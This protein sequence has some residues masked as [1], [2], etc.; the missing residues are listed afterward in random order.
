MEGFTNRSASVSATEACAFEF[1]DSQGKNYHKTEFILHA[2]VADVVADIIG[3]VFYDVTDVALPFAAGSSDL[4][5]SPWSIT[6]QHLRDLSLA[7]ILREEGPE[8]SSSLYSNYP[9]YGSAIAFEPGVWDVTDGLT[10]GVTYPAASAACLYLH[11]GTYC[12]ANASNQSYLK[13]NELQQNDDG[14][15]IYCPYAFR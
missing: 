11:A 2:Q 6:P 10:N 4:N 12:T 5:V 14:M 7:N 8:G 15:T 3:R 13:I 9:I 1:R